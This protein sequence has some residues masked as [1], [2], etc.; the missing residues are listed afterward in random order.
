MIKKITLG[1]LLILFT[2]IILAIATG[3]SFLLTAI[4]RTY[5]DGNA[6]ANINDHRAFQTNQIKT[7]NR[8]SLVKHPQYNQVPL[9]SAFV[10]DLIKYDAAAY[11]VI[12]DGKIISE[13]YFKDYHE[14]SKTNSFSMAKPVLTMMVGV[15][16]E[17]GYIESMD[18]KL[19][20]YLPEF[21]DDPFGKEA[22][23]GQLSLMNSGYEW[24]EHYY[25]PFSPTVEL[26][27]GPNVEKFLLKGKFTA[28]PGSFWEYSS[29]STQLLG[30][31]L[32]RALEKHNIDLTLSQF[33]SESIWQP[34]EMNDDALWHTDDANLEL[35]FCCLNTNARNYAK[36]GLL[37]LNNGTWNGEQIIPAAFIEKMIEPASKPFYGYSTWL[38][39]NIEPKH[40]LFSGHLGQFIIVVPEHNMVVVRL[41]ER[42]KPSNGFLRV[43]VPD[44]VHQAVKLLQ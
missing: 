11:L 23:V 12:V 43:T 19:I 37:M 41:G 42:S 30:I 34:L 7:V 22:T 2:L 20:N 17:S 3:N 4:Q 1:L 35:V 9:E 14:R 39:Y 13:H 6:T 18:E 16:I 38:N 10:N 40:Y 29:A 24:T 44:Y 32:K 28:P 25:S 8:Q 5:L 15:A 31:V 33:L 36:L 21:K 27:Y 26:L